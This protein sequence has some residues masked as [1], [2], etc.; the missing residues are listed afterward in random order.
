MTGYEIAEKLRQLSALRA[1]SANLAK[2]YAEAI[3]DRDRN[4]AL[5]ASARARAE[6]TAPKE[7]L[8]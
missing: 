3:E 5:C 6:S 4:A 1:E 7:V 2:Q 8:P